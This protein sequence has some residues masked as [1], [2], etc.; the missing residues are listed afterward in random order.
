M[1]Q[2]RRKPGQM[3]NLT[4]QKTAH[5]IE[6]GANWVH[7][8]NHELSAIEEEFDSTAA[9]YEQM[10]AEWGYRGATDGAEEFSRFGLQDGKVIDVGCGTGLVGK[11]IFKRGFK[12]LYGCDISSRMLTIA[13]EKRI[14]QNLYRSDIVSMP[15]DNEQFENLVCVAVLTYAPDVFAV[16][17][18]F[19]RIVKTGGI[20]FFSHR[21]DLEPK[22]R[23][24][25]G[26]DNFTGNG[27][28]SMLRVSEPKLY[29]PGR[30]DY[31]VDILVRYYA[32]RKVSA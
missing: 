22:Y 1:I 30:E 7:C 5:S 12:H 14:Y 11:E 4:P 21:V 18:E 26:L 16:M 23:F 27:L 9:L 8:P 2:I 24:N 3:A 20:I 17:Q 25:V 13:K 29:Y 10:S 28:W 31:S 32:Y 6:V 19:Q 15:F